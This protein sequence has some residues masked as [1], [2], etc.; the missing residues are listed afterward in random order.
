MS[1]ALIRERLG[2]PGQGKTRSREYDRLRQDLKEID[3]GIRVLNRNIHH[4]ELL[5]EPG[6]LEDAIRDRMGLTRKQGG[7]A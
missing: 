5:Q 1:E 3:E 4:L 7:C 6:A 2:L